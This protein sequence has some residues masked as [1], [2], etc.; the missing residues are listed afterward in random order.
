MTTSTTLEVLIL[1]NSAGFQKGLLGV[2]KSLSAWGANIARSA[3]VAGVALTALSVGAVKVLK[4][5]A[6]EAMES[7]DAIAEMNA[8]IKSTGGIAGVT[9]AELTKHA[10]ALQLVTK[11][12]DEEI[13]SGQ[14]MLLTFTRIGKDV[15]PIATEAM[16][17]MAEKF[18]SIESASI[19]L[20]KAL[21][22]P[23]KGVTALRR[24]GVMLTDEQ[25][26]QIKKFMAVNDVASAQKIILGE[27]ETEFGGLALA[28]GQTTGGA[29]VRLKNAFGEFKETL[30]RGLLPVFQRFVDLV[31]KK[32]GEPKT[33]LFIDM[34]A[35]KIWKYGTIAVK[36]LED[37][38]NGKYNKQIAGVWKEISD[39]VAEFASVWDL[40]L[41][42]AIKRF[43]TWLTTVFF[44]K[45]GEL[46]QWLIDVG[47]PEFW[48]WWDKLSTPMQNV[49]GAVLLL[50]AAGGLPTLVS[51]LQFAGTIIGSVLMPV[52]GALFTFITGTAIPA[53]SAFVIGWGFV[54][55]PILL[56]IGAIAL[57]YFAFK[58]NFGGITDT[59]VKLNFIMKYYLGQAG[60]TL[61]MIGAIIKF[62]VI[63]AFVSFS[64]K[65]KEVVNAVKLAWNN[66]LLFIRKPIVWPKLPS[67]LTPGSPTPFELGLR[68]I[69]SAMDTLSKKSLPEMNMGFNGMTP[70]MAG[71]GSGGNTNVTNNVRFQQATPA[72]DRRAV[73]DVLRKTTGLKR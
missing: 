20:G 66:F 71:V 31:T 38:A 3:A 57:L 28:M 12:S 27:L 46:K 17:N 72:V 26:A 64:N 22:D 51:L 19:Q 37:L 62:Y 49:A 39:T 34:L 60:N 7:E 63:A 70:A 45:L 55:G 4:N 15:F 35:N 52:L 67:W 6:M 8:V 9:T 1:A 73:E 25:E 21:Q 44:P 41:L 68:G 11:F 65:V 43:W 47:L 29:I 10:N 24:V 69:S 56:I 30:G 59:I 53:I 33:L 48:A 5:L 40:I 32:M 23:V 58:T 61:K 2:G 42:P 16:L 18:G 14:S 54:L 50:T 13:E 36:F